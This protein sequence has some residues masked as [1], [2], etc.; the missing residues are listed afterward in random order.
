MRSAIPLILGMVA[1]WFAFGNLFIDHPW[2][3][4]IY[5]PLNDFALI[6]AATAFILGG[7]NVVQTNWPKIRRREKDWQFKV[8]L[9]GGALVM[10]LVGVRWHA[11][12]EE[13]P[14]ADWEQTTRGVGAGD[15]ELAVR[16]TQKEAL[17]RIDGSDPLRAWHQGDPRDV[18][19][20]PGDQPLVVTQA[21]VPE[22]EPGEHRIEV[23]MPVRGYTRFKRDMAFVPGERVE[24]ETNLTMLW[25][26]KT[27]EQGRVFKW[28]YNYVFDP[29]NSTMFALLAFFIASAAFRAFRARNVESALLLGSAILVMLGLIPIGRAITPV[30]PEVASWLVDVPNNAGRRAIMMG[31][32]LGAIATGLRVILGLERAHLGRE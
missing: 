1:G 23:L 10:A 16:T 32:A 31:A 15:V 13:E 17:V 21:L 4:A 28:F 24:L 2:F 25:G 11:L 9:L 3:K 27:G 26:A 20:E 29:C 6:L 19:S 7:L 18:W 5:R 12:G 14:V 30:F 8:V 22:L